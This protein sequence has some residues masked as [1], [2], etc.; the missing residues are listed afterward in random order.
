MENKLYLGVGREVITP[1]IGTFLSGYGRSSR[2]STAV[3]DDL[4]ATVFAFTCGD[5]RAMMISLTV[6]LL[7]KDIS[8]RIRHEIEYRYGIQHSHIIV[9]AMHTHSAPLTF[10]TKGFGTPDRGYVEEIL[11]PK[12]L[13]AA[14]AAVENTQY[15]RVSV[16]VGNS[17]VGVNRRELNAKNQIVLGQCEYGCFDPKMTILSFADAAGA[18]VANLIHYGC[19][20]TASGKNLEVTRDW[21]GV[22]IDRLEEISGGIT[23]F[24]NGTEGDVGPRLSNRKTTGGGDIAYAI[25]IGEMAAQDAIEIYKKA[26]Y[27][28]VGLRCAMRTVSLPVVARISLAEAED[29]LANV[30]DS[31]PTHAER[32]RMHYREVIE[33]YANGYEETDCAAYEQTVIMIGDTAFVSSS[34]ETFSEI[35]LRISKYS[36]IPHVLCVSMANGCDSYFPT[37][38]EIHR[39][40]YEVKSVKTERVQP[41]SE[42]ADYAFVM[43]TLK[44]LEMLD[45]E[46]HKQ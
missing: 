11:I 46:G 31:S 19:H 14:K 9:H 4:T 41:L 26:N 28:D 2:D 33:S 15:V 7:D 45:W 16:S 21:P 39:G 37:K 42:D 44:T 8:D 12:T 20:A 29:R 1:K 38:G 27:R 17:Y 22:M 18:C 35:G 43:E 30:N 10:T 25:E 24:I 32:I 13:A 5:T 40:G 36:D 34:F 23:A 6:T 3:H